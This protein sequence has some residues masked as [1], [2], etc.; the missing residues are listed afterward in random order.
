MGTDTQPQWKL[1]NL[2]RYGEP[3][4][5]EV[6][7][8]RIVA[9]AEAT[10]DEHPKHLSGEL[11]PPVFAIVPVFE[12]LMPSMVNVVPGELLM[13]GVPGEQGCRS[14]QPI[15]PGMTLVTRA[16]PVGV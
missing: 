13:T 1:D 4:E 9:Y 8:E 14:H 2:G 11:A 6:T 10:N 3:R 7:K 16:A 12:S 15:V 5:F